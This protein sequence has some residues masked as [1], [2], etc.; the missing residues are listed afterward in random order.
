MKEWIF[1]EADFPLLNPE[2]FEVIFDHLS[3]LEIRPI[4]IQTALRAVKRSMKGIMKL[5][6]IEDFQI[7]IESMQSKINLT[8]PNQQLEDIEALPVGMVIE[9]PEF[10]IV[11]R[12]MKYEKIFLRFSE[13]AKYSDG[14]LR[15]VVQILEQKLKQEKLI[16]S[17]K[18]DEDVLK[19]DEDMLLKALDVVEERLKGRNIIRRFERCYDQR[20]KKFFAFPPISM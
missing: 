17:K 13:V 18:G 19:G 3:S 1:S 5:A 16:K 8:V 6:S 20:P 9:N 4:H 7:G 14:T 12:N 11:F 15:M 10:G 2:D